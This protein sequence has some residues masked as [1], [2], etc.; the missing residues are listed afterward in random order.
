MKWIMAQA[1]KKE[2]SPYTAGLWLAVAFLIAVLGS[3]QTLGA[4]GALENLSGMITGVI[5]PALVDNM[6]FKFI[7][8]PGITWQVWLLVG[9]FLGAFLSAKLSGDFKIRWTPE[10]QWNQVFGPQRWKRWVIAFIG[11]VI[12]E[13]GAGIAGGCTS[14]LAISGGIELA[15]A[16]FLFIFGMFASGMLTARVIYRRK[17]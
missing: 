11:G 10:V 14:G 1:R 7:M 17:F 13:Y 3:D 2:W 6:Y 9:V 16:A 12:V 5:S 15:P 4:S 8:P